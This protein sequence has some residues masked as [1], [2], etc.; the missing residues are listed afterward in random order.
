MGIVDVA[1]ASRAIAPVDRPDDGRHLLD[2]DGMESLQPLGTPP[3]TTTALPRVVTPLWI[4]W[5]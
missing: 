2:I 3:W 1:V 5:K 4:Y